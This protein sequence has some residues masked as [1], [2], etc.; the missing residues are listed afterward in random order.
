MIPP[1]VRLGPIPTSAQ[2]GERFAVL[3][4]EFGWLIVT[5]SMTPGYF[6]RF[7]DRGQRSPVHTDNLVCWM[8]QDGS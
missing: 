5:K 7:D 3:H 4:R 6:Y 2:Q 8:P 1:L